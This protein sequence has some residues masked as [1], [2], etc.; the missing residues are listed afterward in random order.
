MASQNDRKRCLCLYRGSFYFRI[1]IDT[2]MEVQLEKAKGVTQKSSGIK[3][4]C[5]NI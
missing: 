1:E 5:Y 2:N 4:Y 3:Y